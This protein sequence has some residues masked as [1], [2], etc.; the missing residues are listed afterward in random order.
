VIGPLS[1]RPIGQ[2][3]FAVRDLDAALERWA[4]GGPWHIYTY[5]P[6]TLPRLSYRGEPGHFTV[7]IALGAQSPQIELVQL[8]AGPSVYDGWVDRH[9]DGVH[10]LAVMVDS[11]DE[12]IAAMGEDG[13]EVAQSGAGYGLDGDGGFAYFDTVA[14]LGV[15]LEA[16]EVPRR[17]REPEL[18]RP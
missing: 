13:F 6:D 17:R 8:I 5:G 3:G 11:L 15:Y 10:H 14:R 7:R 16:V 2:V 4:G 1:G 18:I 12:S 9:G